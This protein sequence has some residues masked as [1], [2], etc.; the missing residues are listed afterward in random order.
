MSLLSRLDQRDLVALAS[1][2]EHFVDPT[3]ATIAPPPLSASQIARR[4]GN[5][6]WL[7]RDFDSAAAHFSTLAGLHAEVRAG[8]C[9]EGGAAG[10]CVCLSCSCAFLVR[11]YA[12]WRAALRCA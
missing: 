3:R 2:E 12:R 11:A 5:D 1:E 7:A 9:E 10:C 6:A 8:P 4:K